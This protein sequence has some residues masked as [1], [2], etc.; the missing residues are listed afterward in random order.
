MV[1]IGAREHGLSKAGCGASF[2]NE[3]DLA[4]A[5]LG[6]LSDAAQVK[7]SG[8]GWPDIEMGPYRA[9]GHGAALL[10]GGEEEQGGREGRTVQT[11]FVITDRRLITP[12]CTP[13]P[14]QSAIAAD[15]KSKGPVIPLFCFHFGL[16]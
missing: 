1:Y 4:A 2:Q 9:V 5:G 3:I 15:R 10:G 6:L 14:P 7:I 13:A 12:I 16:T 11:T 8:R